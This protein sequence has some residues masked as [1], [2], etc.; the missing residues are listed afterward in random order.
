LKQKFSFYFSELKFILFLTFS[1]KNIQKDLLLRNDY[2]IYSS[3][4]QLKVD[5][6][7][8]NS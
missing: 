7:P 4:F 1:F 2:L 6:K 5:Y 3:G 8:A